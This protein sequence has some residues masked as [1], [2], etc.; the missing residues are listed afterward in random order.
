MSILGKKIE[1]DVRKYAKRSAGGIYVI[2]GPV[3]GPQHAVIG[4]NKVWVPQYIYKL[5]YDQAKNK[6]W[7]YWIANSETAK[8]TEPISYSELVQRTRINFI[9]GLK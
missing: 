7:A 2:S 1:S 5:V 9:V 8:V 4:P 3:F 6:A